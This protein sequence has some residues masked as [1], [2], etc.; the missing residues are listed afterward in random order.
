MAFSKSFPKTLPGTNYPIW[1]EI[2]LTAAEEREAEEQC[3]RDNF[4][5]MDECLSEAQSL[6]I[7]KRINEDIIVSNIAVALFEKRASHVI[8]L[9]ENKA[10][11]KFEEKN[12]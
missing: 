8:F 11:E 12:K 4:L 7:K 6:A 5:L 9:K 1:E 10:K 3:K 2:F